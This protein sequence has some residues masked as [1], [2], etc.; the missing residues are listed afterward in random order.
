MLVIGFVS[1]R[2][3]GESTDVVAAFRRGLRDGGFIEGQNLLIAFRWADGRYDRLPALAAE[4]VELRVAVMFSAGGPPAAFAAKAATQT[5]PVVFSAVNDPARLGLV[6]ALN[7]P[8]GN[9]TGSSTF[10]VDL[11]AKS[12]QLLK[13]LVPAATLVGY[14]VN[15]SNPSAEIY[16]KEA[17]TTARTLGIAIRVLNASAVAELDEVFASLAK[18]GVGALVV[19]G[20]PFF[21]AQRDRIVALAAQHAIPAVYT[22]REYALAGG[23]MSYGASLPDAYRQGGLYVGRILKGEKPADLPVIQ[24]TKLDFVLN[25]KT[26]KALGLTVPDRVLALADEVIE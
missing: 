23:L 21:D 17:E 13:E 8:G 15:P 12:I 14:L 26:A 9:L 10:T 4:L 3:P 7:R 24:P 2:S 20:E 5:I 1:S 19:P 11:A 25:L 6:A 22:W 16:V 18:L